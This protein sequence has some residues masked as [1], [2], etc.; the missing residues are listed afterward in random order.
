M[1][2]PKN[3]PKRARRP[4]GEAERERREA[5]LK[6]RELFAGYTNAELAGSVRVVAIGMPGIAEHELLLVAADRLISPTP[7][8]VDVPFKIGGAQVGGGMP[9]ITFNEGQP[10]SPPGAEGAS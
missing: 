4:R 10:F 6:S 9:G 2:T 7:L 5:A 3:A 1:T 8:H